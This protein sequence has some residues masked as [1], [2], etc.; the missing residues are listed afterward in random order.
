MVLLN[1]LVT[2]ALHADDTRFVKV[3]TTGHQDPDLEKPKNKNVFY[4]VEDNFF[5][6]HP[7][8]TSSIVVGHII[9]MYGY[10][11]MYHQLPLYTM[12]W[13]GILQLYVVLSIQCG[14]HALWGHRC[15]QAKWPLRTFFMVGFAFCGQYTIFTWASEHR[16]HHKWSESDSD[17]FNPRRGWFYAHMG[18]SFHRRHPAAL[19]KSWTLSFDD[20]RNDPVVKFQ[21]DYCIPIFIAL[22]ALSVAVP[23]VFWNENLMTSILLCFVTR[24][25]IN[26][27]NVLLINSAAHIFGDKTY[28]AN[29]GP[30][31]NPWCSPFT[32]GAGYHNFHH[33]FPQDYRGSEVGSAPGMN[34]GCNFVDLMCYLGQAYN[35]KWTNEKT[36]EAAKARALANSKCSVLHGHQDEWP[37]GEYMVKWATVNNNS[38]QC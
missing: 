18:W 10:Y 23:V 33:T 29:I 31:D 4:F 16:C 5:R 21:T 28:T 1:E 7:V 17:P 6:A 30:A 22:S 26:L 35:L 12:I 8:Y 27:H 11:V 32:M 24:N 38:Q 15:Y 20:L 25:L 19:E 37:E 9:M 3:V 2:S 13:S 34:V 36:I 14:V